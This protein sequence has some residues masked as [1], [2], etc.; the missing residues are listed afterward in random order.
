MTGLSPSDRAVR[1]AIYRAFADQ[2]RPPS[3]AEIAEERN[4]A[5]AAVRAAL[6]N[7]HDAH[8]IVLTPAGDAVRMA[9]PF[10]AA[11]MGF[12]VGADGRDQSGYA[13][14]RLWWGGCGWDS[15]GIGAALHEPIL[16]RTQCPGCG[17]VLEE[18]AGP[19]APPGLDLVVHIPRPARRWWDD[20]VATCTNIRFF[21]DPS[22]VDAWARSSPYPVGQV[23]TSRTMWQLAQT[24]YADRLAPDW[25]PRPVAASQRL[26][27]QCGLTGD[28][29]QLP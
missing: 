13:G 7:L 15:F 21:C 29:W 19:S 1:L 2:G 14:D 27:G 17:R 8:A 22:H 4:L 16:I 9:H 10:S 23:I 18:R 24:W 3:V 11:P 6:Q 28:F 20:V 12:V 26:L 5:E 25:T